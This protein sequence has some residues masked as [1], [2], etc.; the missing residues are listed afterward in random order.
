MVLEEAP[1]NTSNRR[2]E[3][4]T[5]MNILYDLDAVVVIAF[6]VVLCLIAVVEV[7]TLWAFA[8]ST[9]LSDSEWESEQW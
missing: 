1:Q 5:S 7:I 4:K 2:P 3:R 8:D 6:F 9:E